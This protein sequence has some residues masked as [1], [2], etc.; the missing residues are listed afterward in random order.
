MEQI[1]SLIQEYGLAV[2]L[3]GLL[4]SVLCGCVKIPIVQAIKKQN[5]G[6]KATT[7]RVTT[8]CTAVVAFFSVVILAAGYLLFTDT[9]WSVILSTRFV[10]KALLAISFAKIAYMIYEGI[11]VVSL[12]K[13]AHR[14]L[15][16]IVE[17]M[18]SKNLNSAADYADVVQSVLT[19]T[20]H[21]PLTEEQKADLVHA[22]AKVKA[23]AES[24]P[25]A[26]N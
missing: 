14:L 16:L 6:E 10:S 17:K 1:L 21:L 20:F 13:G 12:K 19:E 7:N 2:V 15:E 24:T 18:K 4:A 11:G 22:L 25:D 9:G 5:L 23:P 8:V 3:A 26:K